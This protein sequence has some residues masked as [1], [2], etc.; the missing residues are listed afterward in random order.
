MF[1]GLFWYNIRRRKYSH[2]RRKG[3]QQ[4]QEKRGG[5][6]MTEAAK[7]AAREARR[8]YKRQWA[9]NNPEK[10]KAQQERYWAKR[11]A[12]QAEQGQEPEETEG[13]QCKMEL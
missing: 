13:A 4:T 10:V 3:A 1:S 7:E 8:Q 6:T 2:K 11:A 12:A 9:K 5:E